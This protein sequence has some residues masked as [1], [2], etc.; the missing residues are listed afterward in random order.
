MLGLYGAYVDGVMKNE[1]NGKEVQSHLFEYTTNVIVENN[2][3]VR[4][5]ISPVQILFCL[6]E[7]SKF[8]S[9]SLVIC[10]G[11]LAVT[12]LARCVCV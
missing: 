3:E 4:G 2:G 10:V 12:N 9:L 5:G 1:V 11:S 7:T 6:K 8:L